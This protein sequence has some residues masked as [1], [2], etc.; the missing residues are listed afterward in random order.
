MVTTVK[1]PI[2]EGELIEQ[3]PKRPSRFK[4]D[5]DLLIFKKKIVDRY[6]HARSGLFVIL[7][8]GQ[9]LFEVL[10]ELLEEKIGRNLGYIPI[11]LPKISPTDTF[12]KANILGKWDDYLQKIIPFSTTKGVVEDY[13]MEPLQCTPL[14]QYFEGKKLDVSTGPLKF[15]DASGP[16]YRNENT[17]EVRPLIKQREFHRSEFIYIGTKKQ[18][19]EIREKTLRKLKELCDDL[20]LRYRIVVGAGCYQISEDEI[21]YPKAIEEI[22]IKD[23][24]IYI[25]NGFFK[26]G[27]KIHYLEVAGVAALGEIQTKRF[28]I[29]SMEGHELWSG[30]TGIGL[31][32]FMYAF[33]ASYGFDKE[34]WPKLIKEKYR[35]KKYHIIFRRYIPH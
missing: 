9:R 7:P 20:G 18:I 22:P 19:I 29:K 15:Y 2:K 14:Y 12:R 16:T 8:E 35:D 13:L 28:N 32:R 27:E 10:K 31:E 11:T 26:R 17:E 5:V 33:L 30:C 4:G 21:E 23:L 1:I 34:Q 25:P 3:G 6:V 24:E